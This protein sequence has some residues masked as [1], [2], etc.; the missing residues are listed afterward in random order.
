M[1]LTYLARA[2][3]RPE[4]IA[5]AVERTSPDADPGSGSVSDVRDVTWVV[6]MEIP[7]LVMLML[8]CLLARKMT[9]MKNS[10]ESLT[11]WIPRPGRPE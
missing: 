5:I 3:N 9:V 8:S 11:M 4:I 10:G 2:L 7:L 6:L 1:T